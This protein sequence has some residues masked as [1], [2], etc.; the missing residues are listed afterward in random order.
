ML[1][2]VSINVLLLNR[3]TVF[4]CS[5]RLVCLSHCLSVYLSARLVSAIFPFSTYTRTRTTRRERRE[6]MAAAAMPSSTVGSFR[7]RR[8]FIVI[9]PFYYV[10][11][12]CASLRPGSPLL[13]SSLFSCLLFAVPSLLL[14]LLLLLLCC[15]QLLR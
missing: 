13:P 14:L 1:S 9:G 8:S 12:L 10:S 15:M 11:L 3:R 2:C 4:A 6:Q 5:V 7:S